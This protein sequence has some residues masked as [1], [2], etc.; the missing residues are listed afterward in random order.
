MALPQFQSSDRIL[1]MLQ[2]AWAS[3]I[4]PF[5]KKSTNNSI[6]LPSVQLIVGTTTINHRLGRKLQGWKIVR[7]RALASIYD[8]QDSNE[9]PELTLKLVSNAVVSVDLE[10]F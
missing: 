8:V 2:T 10:V 5:L 9:M 1:Q 7:Q 3:K 6:V 4:E